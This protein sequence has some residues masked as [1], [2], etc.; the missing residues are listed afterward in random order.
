MRAVEMMMMMMIMF[1]R[2]RT[3]QKQVEQFRWRS[4]KSQRWLSRGQ[5]LRKGLR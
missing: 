1:I 5:K 2:R 3:A 4:R